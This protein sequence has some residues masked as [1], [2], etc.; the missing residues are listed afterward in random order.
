M[1]YIL[2]MSFFFFIFVDMKKHKL[3]S[4]K[5]KIV[6]DILKIVER[7]TKNIERF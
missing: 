2:Y 7:K 4:L 1:T 6:F 3:T 5:I